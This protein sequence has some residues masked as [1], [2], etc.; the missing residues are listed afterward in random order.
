MRKSFGVLFFIVCFLVACS[1]SEPAIVKVN[2]PPEEVAKEPE[3]I[4]ELTDNEEVDEFIEFKLADEVLRV[5]LKQIPI[6][7][8]YL[9]AAKDR[10]AVI[11]KM[12][13]QQIVNK[14][15]NNIYL[16]EF[17]CLDGQCSYLLLDESS[18]NTGLLVADLALFDHVVLSPEETKLFLKFNREP[19][20]ELPLSNVVVIDLENWEVLPLEN[21][22]IVNN[23]FDY[24]WPI[25]SVNWID[26]GTL[27]ISIPDTLDTTKEHPEDSNSK[28]NEV[29][30]TVGK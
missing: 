16:L 14:E 12:D 7:S 6:L 26:E 15:E 11:E 29:I 19:T 3:L 25:L 24:H 18:E 2:T 27:S 13:I 8:A 21:E 28:V 22:A 1:N 4:E 5:N 30:F 20:H 10:Q 17:S 9:H 23:L